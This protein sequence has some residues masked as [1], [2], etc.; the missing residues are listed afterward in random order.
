MLFNQHRINKY[1]FFVVFSVN[2]ITLLSLHLYL[3]PNFSYA[4]DKLIQILSPKKNEKVNI[5]PVEIRLQI[6]YQ[7][8]KDSL[9][10]ELNHKNITDRFSFSGNVAVAF[11]NADDVLKIQTNDDPIGKGLNLLKAEIR[12]KTNEKQKNGKK[13]VDTI[14]FFV[15][16]SALTEVTIK[17]FFET[18]DVPAGEGVIIKIDGIQA[19]TTGADGTFKAYI[20]VGKKNV[21]AYLPGVTAGN[22]VIDATS[23]N[24]IIVNIVMESEQLVEPATLFIGP[25]END[26][27]NVKF[28]EFKM[29]FEEK[30]RVI[31]LSKL[32]EV[33]FSRVGSGTF[34]VITSYFELKPNGDILSIDIESL[35][36]LLFSS[37]GEYELEVHAEDA[38]G[39]I[40][41]D[42]V[43]FR[44]GKYL[45]EGVLTQPP[46]NTS[47]SVSNLIIK[48]SLLGSEIIVE[49]ISD[50]E[51]KFVLESLP[52]GSWV[53]DVET[54]D[55][56]V[57]YWFK[58][59][60]TINAD[61]SIII[62]MRSTEDII[63]G[64]P[65]ISVLN[66]LGLKVFNNP[67]VKRS[68]NQQVVNKTNEIADNYE[69][70]INA[71]GISIMVSAIG[72]GNDSD[73]I[74]I[75][76]GVQTIVVEYE[77]S[78]T[79]YPYYVLQPNNP[80]NDRWSIT[81]AGEPGGNLWDLF[82]NIN[83]QVSNEP[84]WQSNGSTGII[85]EEIDVSLLTTN[86]PA[87]IVIECKVADV[88]DN[89][90]PTTVSATITQQPPQPRISIRSVQ[91]SDSFGAFYSIPRSGESNVF[92]R[93]FI[94]EL[95][96]LP[97]NAT[98]DNVTVELL[99]AS[100]GTLATIL[101]TEPI[102]GPF[103]VRLSDDP[104]VLGITVSMH[105]STYDSNQPGA[106][107][108]KYRFTVEGYLDQ[109]VAY[110]VKESGVRNALWQAP[111]SI[112][113]FGSRDPG[114]D[115]WCSYST[116]YWLVSNGSILKI[117]DISGE[118][119]RDIGHKEH[120]E[121]TDID[122]YHFAELDGLNGTQNYINLSKK[123]FGAFNGS[124]GDK[125]QVSNWALA[126]QNGLQSL[127]VVSKR[128]LFGNGSQMVS[129]GPPPYDVIM[130]PSGWL[131][132]LITQGS[133]TAGLMDQNGT[134]FDSQ[135]IQFTQG[136]FS[137]SKMSFRNDHNNHVHIDVE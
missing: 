46:S 51:G 129:Q 34:E 95:D 53:I 54:L 65:G 99:T 68:F 84:L 63:A 80:F 76:Q 82:R 85:K 47:L 123:I 127:S 124:N 90:F 42:K 81:I 69:S 98:I 130:L 44:I 28:E 116:Y 43:T 67:Q 23:S 117:N 106:D 56:G 120:K 24:N 118:H 128:I 30:G 64:V 93:N 110:A 55:E 105:P 48:A 15:K 39:L 8:D 7:A 31:S 83:D 89:L 5:Y 6:N 4:S 13:G 135:T 57:N 61:L 121:G 29:H 97:L 94:V 66:I 107:R 87:T 79:E 11:L 40:Y 104:P 88:G 96:K 20:P 33:V 134:I 35:K 101:A 72:T 113:R 122:S 60:V 32:N 12:A 3:M 86:S 77:V 10:V 111:T 49:T 9:I 38:E 45:L 18:M 114:G 71:N 125:E 22:G 1:L 137:S 19:G 100:G 133:I 14:T 92:E 132:D 37:F 36:S 41:N 112:V 91:P 50:S 17:T 26:I 58:D 59:A 102:G 52:E 119:G 16:E 74:T 108:I 25:V 115:E 73:S 78:T 21:R 70:F 126:N 27:L 62:T 131:K 2:F 103:V 75:D 136:G 109:Q